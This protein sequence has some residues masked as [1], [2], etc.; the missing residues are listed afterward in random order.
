TVKQAETFA[1]IRAE[2]DIERDDNLALRDYP[3][4]EHVIGF[5][6][7][8]RPDLTTKGPGA[9]PTEA[10]SPEPQAAAAAVVGDDAAAAEV[11]RRI[12][13]P[14]LRPELDR[15]SPTGVE[16]DANTR[17]VVML[18]QGGVGK[19]LVKRLEA[20]SVSV[21]AIGDAPDAPQL[22]SRLDEFGAAGPITGVYW[23]AA[24]D[25]EPGLAELDLAGWRE[26]LRKRVKLLYE[27]MRHLYDNVGERGTFLVA[28]T[29]LGGLHGYG[30]DGATAPMGGSVTGFTKAF[31]REKPLALV[32]AVDLAPSRKT[33]AIA[34]ILVSETLLDPGVVEVGYSKGH[35]WTISLEEA[36]LP[37]ESAGIKLDGDSV[38]VVTGAAGS[39]VAAITADLARASGGT[40]HLL[41]LIPEPDRS[42][43][44]LA[45]FATDRDGLKRAIFD[46]LKESTERATPA[47]VERELAT[48]E[49]SHSALSAIAAVEAAGGTAH[50]HSLNLLDGTAV[51]AAMHSVRETS[52]KVDVLLHAGGLEISRHLQDK[53]RSEF[54]LV[55]DVKADGW[56]N[57]LAGLGDTPVLSSVVF[58]SVA[59]RFGND[60]QTDYSAANDLLCKLTANQ[61]SAGNG[62]LGVAIDWTAWGDIGMATRGSIPTVMAAAGIDMLP[63]AAGIPIVRR[64]ITGRS[65][66][67]EVVIGL[68]LGLLLDEFDATGGMNT[69]D[70][71]MVERTERSVM[72]GHVERF[73]LYDGL[74]V[75]TRLDPAE[76][77]F[78]FDHRIDGTPVLPGV[79]GLEAFA[80]AAALPYPGLRVAAIENVDFLAPFKFYRDEPRDLRIAVQYVADG[81][82]VIGHC[83][84]IGERN[85][86]GQ[87]EPKRTVHFRGAVRLS[88]EAADLP[89]E[90]PPERGESAVMAESIY[91]IYFHGPA[92]QVTEMAWS[93]DGA[94]AASLAAA[95]PPNSSPPTARLA[96]APR[97]A[98]LAFQAAG[99]LEIGTTGV[100][101]LPAHIDRVEYRPDAQEPGA[102][103]VVRKAGDGFDVLVVDAEGAGLVQMIG[104]DT[105]AM[106]VPIDDTILAPLRAAMSDGD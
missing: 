71:G 77:P 3:T 1:A 81:D 97:L 83:R 21:L 51:A 86:A 49:R 47:M 73:G 79:M 70:A 82:D 48:I 55:F 54:D 57:L 104:Y 56:F 105:V 69:A 92:Y 30:P 64:E 40:F 14:V 26:H 99:V 37:D 72:T 35:R 13:T 96:T 59:G 34:D 80:A 25:M 31:K 18:D 4:L 27:T 39:I 76:Q 62:T 106:P 45:A 2:Y 41:D 52:G 23:L 101:A 9:A 78:L 29:R 33:A 102:V 20:E 103:A 93:Q 6:H 46:R 28:A 88:R 75:T 19:A 94:A 36:D 90:Q 12:P 5:V 7:E 11:P 10:T 38:I 50:Y 68:R 17:V 98:E 95:L 66:G 8:R 74:V 43:P 53:E 42:D 16:L 24:L 63:A 44:D 91:Q 58:S 84:L 67:G 65:S 85:L 100:M 22:Q 32:K 60:G 61:R 89:S 87:A 15:C